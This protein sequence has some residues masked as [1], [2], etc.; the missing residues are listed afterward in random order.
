VARFRHMANE[1]R[2]RGRITQISTTRERR[3]RG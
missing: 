1:K 3:S 2:H